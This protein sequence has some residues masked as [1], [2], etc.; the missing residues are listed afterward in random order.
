MLM[1]F[2][3]QA[4]K[5]DAVGDCETINGVLDLLQYPQVRFSA[6]FVQQLGTRMRQAQRFSRA[7]T[8]TWI[9]RYSAVASSYTKEYSGQFS[10]YNLSDSQPV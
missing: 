8:N 5:T 1:Y 10:D 9:L 6:S 7:A 2:A 3:G 4:S